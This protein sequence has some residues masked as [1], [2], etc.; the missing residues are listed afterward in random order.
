MSRDTNRNE[1]LMLSGFALQGILSGSLIT[2][3]PGV[4]ALHEQREVVDLAV[5][6][7]DAILAKIDAPVEAE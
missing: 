7:A 5:S 1:R 3:S 2:G 4:R 6:Y